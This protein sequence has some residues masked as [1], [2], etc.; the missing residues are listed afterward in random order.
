MKVAVIYDA[1]SASQADSDLQEAL[2]IREEAEEITDR[3]K[4]SGFEACLV[5][6]DIPIFNSFQKLVKVKPDLVFNL[7]EGLGDDSTFEIYMASF[8]EAMK[9]PF[10]GTGPL[11]LGL[12][13]DK[14]VTK[15]LL[16]LHRIPTPKCILIEVNQKIV[17][18]GLEY[19][20]IVKPV[21][22]D[23]SFGID[24]HS[25]VWEDRSLRAKVSAI[26]DKFNQAA[27]VEEYIDGR[28][29]NVSILGNDPF[30]FVQI[31][32]I[33][34]ASSCEPKIVSYQA[35][36]E[37]ESE[38][39]Q[40]TVSVKAEHLRSAIRKEIMESAIR[41][42]KIF[43]L[44]DYARVDFRLGESR[45]PYVIDINPNPCLSKDSGMSMAAQENGLEYGK[46]IGKI[47]SLGLSRSG[48]A[49]REG[50]SIQ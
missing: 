42:F 22:E 18:N 47:A 21:H 35:K 10:T 3:L 13:R 32:E 23:G 41:C 17:R 14:F 50:S 12:C 43:N 49:E 11:G 31:R 9:I 4:S 7:C 33:R 38:V 2:D 28:E 20:L 37:K 25:V 19:P 15:G 5:G 45:I 30:I 29:F 24:E 16:N 34:F 8:L 39:Y 26:H 36:W 44:R 40:G 1:T 27:M 6:I 46:L 48:L